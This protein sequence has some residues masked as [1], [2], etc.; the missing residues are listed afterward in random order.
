MRSTRKAFSRNA[1]RCASTRIAL[2]LSAGIAATFAGCTTNPPA[3]PEPVSTATLPVD[4]AMQRRDWPRTAAE[5][6]SGATIAG[7]TRFP[8]APQTV[9]DGA[10]YA[11]LGPERSNALLDNLFFIG[12]SIALPFTYFVDPPFV[13][14]EYRGVIYEPTH[15][16]MPL[17][18]PDEVPD[19]D[20]YAPPPLEDDEAAERE[21]AP[22]GDPSVPRLRDQ[23][24]PDP[25]TLVPSLDTPVEAQPPTITREGSEPAPAEPGEAVKTEPEAAPQPETTEPAPEPDPAPTPEAIEPAPMPEAAEPAPEPEAVTPAPEV[26]EP[27]PEQ[28]EPAPESTE[29]APDQPEPTPSQTEAAAEQPEAAPEQT[30]PAPDQAAPAPDQTEPAPEENK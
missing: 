17:L 18:P 7:A 24:Q 11:V 27:M 26:T 22:S 10:S 30:E 28:P 15:F 13:K 29:P 8:Y 20:A 9:G 1:S 12:Q 16:A 5:F 3:K 14:K 6:E 4:E 23:I 2:A 25:D 19:Y 21:S